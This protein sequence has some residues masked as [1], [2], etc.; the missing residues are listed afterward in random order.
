MPNGLKVPTNLKTHDGMS[1]PDDHL[2]ELKG[3][4]DV[5]KLPEPAWCRFCHITLSGAAR[6]WRFQKTQ[7]RILRIRQHSNE[8]LR[9]YLGRF[10]KET[11]HMTDRSNGMMTRAFISRLRPG[12]FF[13]NLIA[14]PPVSMED[15]FTQAHNFI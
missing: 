2:I 9:D 14:R 5:H 13:K 10:G 8:S 6:F 15:L 11:L 12:R 1:D 4:I 7:A 3:T